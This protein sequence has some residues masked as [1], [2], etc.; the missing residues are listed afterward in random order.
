MMYPAPN[1]CH[2]VL[3]DGMFDRRVALLKTNHHYPFRIVSS[4]NPELKI[5]GASGTVW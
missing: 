2:R 3:E 1:H 4:I 5:I